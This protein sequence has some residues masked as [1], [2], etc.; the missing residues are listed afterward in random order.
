MWSFSCMTTEEHA[1]SLVSRLEEKAFSS[2]WFE[3]KEAEEVSLENKPP[4]WCVEALFEQKPDAQWLQTAVLPVQ[5]WTLEPLPPKDWLLHNRQS[6]PVLDLDPF[7]IYGS[8]HE[9]TLHIPEGKIPLKIDAATAFGT[10][11]HATTQ[12]CLTALLALKKKGIS[13]ENWLDLGCG[14]AILGMAMARLFGVSGSAADNDPEAVSRATNTVMENQLSD[15]VSV[16]LSE[17]F[18]HPHFCSSGKYDVIMANILANCL[19][20]LAPQ[21]A[22]FTK[23]SGYV[24]LSGILQ[25]QGDAVSDVYE[26]H[27]FKVDKTYPQAEWVTLLMKFSGNL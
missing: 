9:P 14:T 6:F 21:M 8:H 18:S 10:G 17:G 20:D 13:V 12:G 2:S 23:P 16:F 25:S 15:F 19:I 22:C 1:A 5:N 11:Q 4:L 26:Q 27:G 24:I 3:R 7:Y